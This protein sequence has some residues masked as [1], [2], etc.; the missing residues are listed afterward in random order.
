M[1]KS[2]Q[3]PRHRAL[4]TLLREYREAAG[5][6]QSELAALIDEPQSF[7][8]KYESGV[9][10]LDLVELDQV[11]RAIGVKLGDVVRAFEET[12]GNEG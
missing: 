5:L 8:S 3:S 6:R 7:V 2:I 4:A 9:R 12:R 1:D 10:R 11:A